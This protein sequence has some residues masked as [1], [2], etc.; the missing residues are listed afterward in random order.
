MVTPDKFL[1]VKILN[2]EDSNGYRTRQP[3]NV[4]DTNE[5]SLLIGTDKGEFAYMLHV[6]AQLGGLLNI[7]GSRWD[8]AAES[9]KLPKEASNG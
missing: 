4:W 5:F 8:Y 2:V 9:G 1:G 7:D 6:T 3:V